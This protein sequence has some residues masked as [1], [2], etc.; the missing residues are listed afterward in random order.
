MAVGCL[1]SAPHHSACRWLF[2]HPF[3][4]ISFEHIKVQA[5]ILVIADLFN[6]TLLTLISWTDDSMSVADWHVLLESQGPGRAQTSGWHEHHIDLADP[7]AKL[8]GCQGRGERMLMNWGSTESEWWYAV[9]RVCSNLSCRH[10][11]VAQCCFELLVY[12]LAK[13]VQRT[14]SA[15]TS[16]HL[17]ADWTTHVICVKER[18]SDAGENISGMV[19]I[20]MIGPPKTNGLII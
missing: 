6:L 10:F 18:M 7:V 16:W 12:G 9:K 20:K 1:R 5:T 3:L 14:E 11:A 13:L 15:V 2:I 8:L 19:W 4:L 17:D